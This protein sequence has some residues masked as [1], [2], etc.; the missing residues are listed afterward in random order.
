MPKRVGIQRLPGLAPLAQIAGMHHER[1]DG[2]G[3]HRGAQASTIP[4][5]ARLLAAADV[6]HAMTEERAHR[7]ALSPASAGNQLSAE[8]AAGRLDRDAVAAVLEAAGM[9][10]VH[11]RA[12][13]PA[14]LTDREVA[15]LR[16]VARGRSDKE[17]ATA[18]SISPNT[19]HHHVKQVYDR[20][21]VSTR[22]GAALFAMEHDLIPV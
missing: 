13:W 6:Y 5:A 10:P 8:A 20:I 14:G 15:V 12:S 2:S 16:L 7:R 22:A 9:K 3:Y 21:E 11:V 4:K 18:M 1:L 19:V 17:I